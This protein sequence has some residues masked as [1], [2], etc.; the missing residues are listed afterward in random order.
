MNQLLRRCAGPLCLLLVA[1]LGSVVT[2]EAKERRLL[3]VAEPGIRDY[4]EYGGCGLLVF[5]MDDGHKFLR[6]IATP[7]LDERGKPLNVKGVC[8]N[9]S[10]K[11]I[12]LS[13]TRALICL[14]LITDKLLWERSYEGG[15]D[16]MSISPDGKTIYLP[17][18]E[19]D[20]WHVVNA[21]TGDVLEKIVPKSGA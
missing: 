3:Y 6:R 9:S 10:S 5:Y 17:S 12:Y 4:L 15:C 21:I 8:A 19:G 2:A 16:R 13:T 7:G 14:D 11:R 18:L 20:H 1:Y